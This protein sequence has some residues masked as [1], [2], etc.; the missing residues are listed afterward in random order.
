M[1]KNYY[2][3]GVNTNVSTQ[4]DLTVDLS[5]WDVQ[6]GSVVSVEEV[7]EKHNGEVT[8]MVTVPQ[9]KILTL[10]QPGSSVWLVTAPKGA[11]S[12]RSF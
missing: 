7:S 12:R 1:S 3:L 4:Y 9:N 8:R 6:P 11:A 10:T 5:G 2:M